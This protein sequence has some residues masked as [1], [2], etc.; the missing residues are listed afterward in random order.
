MELIMSRLTRFRLS[1][2]RRRTP[3]GQ[4]GFTLV[5]LLVVLG[6]LALVAAVVTPQV[7]NYLSSARIETAGIQI[8]S[9]RNAL[10]LYYLDN[11]RYP[12]EEEGLAA[13]SDAPAG[14]RNWNG[15]YLKNIGQLSDP[16]GN[17]YT[18]RR[19]ADGGDMIVRSLGRDGRE[20]GTGE[21]GD[22]P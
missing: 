3:S 19:A 5:E 2:R 17:P 10:E 7:L 20:G 13:L 11:G 6:I 9:L 14:A 15:P 21:D 22:I 12:T 8:R 4:D 18:Y 16:W 1:S